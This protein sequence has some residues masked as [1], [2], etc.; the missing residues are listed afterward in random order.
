MCEIL[1]YFF[2]F[3]NYLTRM[4]DIMRHGAVCASKRNRMLRNF[5]RGHFLRA[6]KIIASPSIK[7]GDIPSEE[8]MSLFHGVP[9][10]EEDQPST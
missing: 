10:R 3:V 6:R 4:K 9:A 2:H 8:R 5:E 1:I 7:K